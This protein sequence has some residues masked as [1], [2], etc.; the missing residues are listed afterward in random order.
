MFSVSFLCEPFNLTFLYV[1]RCI[2]LTYLRWWKAWQ[3]DS[4]EGLA[5]INSSSDHILLSSSVISR[6]CVEGL[7]HWRAFGP[8]AEWLISQSWTKICALGR[9]VGGFVFVTQSENS[10]L[11]TLEVYVEWETLSLISWFS[12]GKRKDISLFVCIYWKKNLMC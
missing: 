1:D 7:F 4:F 5:A 11:L 6:G 2:P 8:L 3:S 12:W 10:C 9:C